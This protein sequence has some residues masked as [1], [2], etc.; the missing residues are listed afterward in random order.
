MC[1]S[2]L[3]CMTHHC[4]ANK[5]HV[6]EIIDAN[7]LAGT[8]MIVAVGSQDRNFY[9]KVLD[10]TPQEVV[11]RMDGYYKQFGHLPRSFVVPGPDQFFSNGPELLRALK[12]WANRHDTFLHIHSSEE[13]NTT[14]W[15]KKEYGMTEVQYAHSLGIL[16]QNTILAHQ[17]QCTQEDLV[18]LQKTGTKIVHNPLANTILGS[19]MPPVIK[20]LEMGI[21]VAISTDGSGSSDSQNILA[22]ARLASQYQ[23]ALHKDARLLPA[24]KVLE[25]ITIEPA[26]MLGFNAGSLAP[27]KDADIVLIDLRRPNLTPSKLSNVVENL[28][29][30][31]DGSEVQYVIANGHLLKDDYRFVTLDERRILH[32]VQVL[33][34]QLD[35]YKKAIGDLKGT[36]ANR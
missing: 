4:G 28:I 5:Y 32:N 3:T 13:Y 2:D 16:D 25:M 17:V 12:D 36:G 15:F 35:D 22:A 21:P 24:Q 33:S 30:A 10:K 18:L 6:Q 31:S 7:E 1:S 11:E 14:E 19:G 27:G 9:E 23:K 8:R 20:M 29:W 26:K 34:E